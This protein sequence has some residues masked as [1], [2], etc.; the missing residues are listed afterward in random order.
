MAKNLK[1]LIVDHWRARH[2][3]IAVMAEDLRR[4]RQ[5]LA[6]VE[7]TVDDLRRELADQ[8]GRWERLAER[9]ERIEQRRDAKK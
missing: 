9:I 5:N 7:A 4:I 2:T 6:H 3:D 8:S 1:E